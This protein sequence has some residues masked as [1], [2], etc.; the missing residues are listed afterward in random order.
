MFRKAHLSYPLDYWN[1]IYLFFILKKRM[2]SHPSIAIKELHNMS[3]FK[4]FFIL[5]WTHTEELLS[6]KVPI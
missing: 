6:L 2:S 3:K 4:T 1:A 5:H